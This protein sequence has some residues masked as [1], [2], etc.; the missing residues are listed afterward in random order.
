MPSSK[1]WTL[2]SPA[3]CHHFKVWFLIFDFSPSF[4]C[5]HSRLFW[6]KKKKRIFSGDIETNA[7]AQRRGRVRLE[8]STLLISIYKYKQFVLSLHSVF[9]SIIC[10]S[11]HEDFDMLCKSNCSTFHFPLL[12]VEIIVSSF[13]VNDAYFPL[14]F[15]V[16]TSCVFRANCASI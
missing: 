14:S 10:F 2:R 11:K 16:F 1:T 3:C 12:V 4:C 13:R 8:I 9:F 7:A 5:R 6:Q 15:F